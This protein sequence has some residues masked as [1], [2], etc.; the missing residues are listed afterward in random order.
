MV[1]S[2]EDL[3][4]TLGVRSREEAVILRVWKEEEGGG[5]RAN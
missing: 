3:K 2:A 4:P 1:Y 5:G